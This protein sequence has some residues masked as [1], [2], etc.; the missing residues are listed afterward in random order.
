[1]VQRSFCLA[2]QSCTAVH[3]NFFFKSICTKCLGVCGHVRRH[4]M[5]PDTETSQNPNA[6]E[7]RGR[8]PGPSGPSTS[9]LLPREKADLGC[10]VMPWRRM[11]KQA[12]YPPHTHHPHLAVQQDPYLSCAAAIGVSWGHRKHTPLLSPTQDVPSVRFMGRGCCTCQ[13]TTTSQA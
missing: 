7:G 6:S 5:K 1:M 2:T 11:L 8:A 4:K 9:Q 3:I 10:S 12:S 13:L